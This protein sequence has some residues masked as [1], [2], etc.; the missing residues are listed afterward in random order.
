MSILGTKSIRR[1]VMLFVASI[2]VLGM[3][4]APRVS[5]APLCFNQPG[6]TACV[7]DEFR[8]FW[9]DNGGLST[10]GY[11]LEAAKQE[12]TPEGTFMVQYFERQ[13][14]E[15]HPATPAP[16][17]ILL[18][19]AN[20]EMLVREGRDWRAFPEAG[21]AAA[22]C[23]SFAETMHSV[24][25]LFLRRW[26]SQG[27]ELGDAGTSYREA[28]A[29]W[30][31]PLS[32]PQ[33]EQN[34]DGDT[35]MTQHFERARM[36]IHTINGEQTVLLTRVGAALV[37][38]T[39]K[40]FAINDF[41]GQ[42]PADRRVSNRPVGGAAYLAAYIKQHRQQTPYSLTVHAGDAVGASPLVSALLQDQPAMDFLNTLGVDVGTVGNHEFDE[43]ITELK[44]LVDGGCHPTAGCW[45]GANFPY[46]VSNVVETAT[47]KTIFPPYLIKNVAGA[48]IGFVGAVLRGT[49]EIVTASGVAGLEFLDE[50]TSINAA[51][52][53]LHEHGVHAI[54]LL[55]HQGG[56]QNATTGELTGA[57][58][59]IAKNID[60]DVDVIASGHSHTSINAMIDGKL[61]TQALSY[62]IAFADID[63]TIDRA[64][65][66]IVAKK[67]EIV[68]TF[69]DAIEPDAEIAALVK[70]YADQTA[71]LANRVVGTLA[72]DLPNEQNEAGESAI[73][74]LIADSQRVG[75]ATQFAF[76]NPGGI[77]APLSAGEITY[78]EL[79]SVQPFG[80]NM[81]KIDLTGDQVYTLLNQQWQP[82]PD[83]SVRTR[84][85]QIS[86]LTY[87]WSDARAVGDKV[88]EI[89]GADGQPID[90][91]ATFSV[92][93]NSFLADGG[94]GFTILRSG[95]NRVGG[96]VDLDVLVDYVMAATQPFS[97]AIEGRIT[98]Q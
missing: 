17:N 7:A 5:A 77:R 48:R 89:R 64:K 74:N 70:K 94:D 92:A 65:R 31:L 91:A 95:T 56:V 62:S 3:V 52:A 46:I 58:A 49:P 45:G 21:T 23:T 44:R 72:T 66:D 83:G 28:L 90:R 55:I 40:V 50:V 4:P 18:G 96:P 54:I 15:L 38:L 84:F 41:H 69:N 25:G 22:G 9:E 42:L 63:L 73:G 26:M 12:Q 27:L 85:L 8:A 76:M 37:P 39:M 86:G 61:I 78:G 1:S 71:P 43:G 97:A 34:I 16:Y 98:K 59:D 20:D 87:T 35:V 88:V 10:F 2:L 81:V 80:N 47:G 75:M 53:E 11:P 19:R 32:E 79:F 36:E 82:Q 51:V 57:I 29:L 67:A 13:R 93:I 14:L 30:G 24:C 68:T 33:Q 6:V 60:D